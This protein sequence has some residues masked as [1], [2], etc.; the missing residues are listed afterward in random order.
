MGVFSLPPLDL[1]HFQIQLIV[2]VA[3]RNHLDLLA[4]ADEI[5][6]NTKKT[7]FHIAH[8]WST[9]T[10]DMCIYKHIKMSPWNHPVVWLLLCRLARLVTSQFHNLYSIRRARNVE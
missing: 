2:I 4:N 3:V 10:F 1:S 7:Q 5:A 9:I 8:F 6:K